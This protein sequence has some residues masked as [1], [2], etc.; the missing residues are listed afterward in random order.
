MGRPLCVA[1]GLLSVAAGAWG[2]LRWWPLFV[3][4]LKAAL[5]AVLVMGGLIAIIAGVA[6]LR[7]VDPPA[8]PKKS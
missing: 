8:G 5:P 1:V 3:L 4:L 7:D 6:D 2:L